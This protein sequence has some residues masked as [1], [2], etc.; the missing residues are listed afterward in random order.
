MEVLALLTLKATEK[1]K[2]FSTPSTPTSGTHGAHSLF[3]SHVCLRGRDF[4]HKLAKSDGVVGS[5]GLQ[6]VRWE[7]REG[8]GRHINK[9]MP[10]SS[11]LQRAFVGIFSA[12][13]LVDKIPKLPSLKIFGLL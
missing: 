11:L 8:R 6:E 4:V 2:A 9:E 3:R 1:Q 10:V 13:Q 5:Q 7:E 12:G